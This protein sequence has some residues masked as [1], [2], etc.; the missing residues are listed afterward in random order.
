MRNWGRKSAA[1]TLCKSILYGKLA[2]GIRSAT[3][4]QQSRIFAQEKYQSF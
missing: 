2:S 3:A 1:L 4:A